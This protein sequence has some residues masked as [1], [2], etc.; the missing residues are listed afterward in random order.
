[1][2]AFSH[3]R[4]IR[5]EQGEEWSRV[6]PSSPLRHSLVRRSSDLLAIVPSCNPPAPGGIDRDLIANDFRIGF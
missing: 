6:G 2:K 4:H 1:M 5:R 3:S